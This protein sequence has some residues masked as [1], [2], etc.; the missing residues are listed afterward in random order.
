MRRLAVLAFVA[1]CYTSG[2]APATPAPKPV[3]VQEQPRHV[4]T[5]AD[6]LGFLPI[7]S[8][9]VAHVDLAQ[10]RHSALWA[11]L[12]PRVMA[13]IGPTF[14]QFRTACGFDV[15]P[16]VK[17]IALGMRD[18]DAPKPSAVVVIRGVDRTRTMACVDK[19]LAGDPKLGSND[20]GVVAIATAP[21][22]APTLFAFADATTLVLVSGPTSTGEQMRHVLDSG[23]PLRGSEAFSEL[24]GK[25]DP[26]RAAWFFINGNAKLLATMPLG[27]KPRAIYA[28]FDVASGLVAKLVM[29]LDDANQAQT[30]VAMVQ[31]QVP[32]A[33]AFVERFEVTADDA[34]VVVDAALTDEQARTISGLLWP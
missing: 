15:L 21:G 11:Q 23:S 9:L 31:S 14:E 18:L 20:H 34:E 29:R 24:Y 3:V 16:M 25:I 28:W 7:D 2:R 33:Q 17:R 22:E 4:R 13:K 5:A 30:L 27:F 6:P 10:L 12:E 1:S 32:A 26:A 8:E 19:A